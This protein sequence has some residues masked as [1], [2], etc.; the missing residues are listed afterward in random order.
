MPRI[1]PNPAHDVLNI[2][3]PAGSKFTRYEITDIKGTVIQSNDLSA[4][5]LQIELSKLEKGMLFLKLISPT[6]T[7]ISKISKW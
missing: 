2:V 3:I 4:G 5:R 1:F 6:R 7:V